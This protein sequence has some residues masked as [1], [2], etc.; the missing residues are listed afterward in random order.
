MGAWAEDT[1]P[2]GGKLWA[3]GLGLGA[4]RTASWGHGLAGN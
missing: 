3:W 4:E 1:Q 2:A